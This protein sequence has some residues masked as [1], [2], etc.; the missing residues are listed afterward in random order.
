MSKLEPSIDGMFEAVLP[1]LDCRLCPCSEMDGD[2][3]T[4]QSFVILLE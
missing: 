1:G 3:A 2:G 4:Y